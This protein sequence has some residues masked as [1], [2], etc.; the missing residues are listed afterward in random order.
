MHK[1]NVVVVAATR[2]TSLA[3][4]L[5]ALL[6]AIPQIDTVEIVTTLE[7]ALRRV[8]E[9]KPGLLLLDLALAGKKPKVILERIS[10]LSPAT[11]RVLLVE[12][13]RDLR[14]KP[15][16]AEAALVKGASPAAIVTILTD[17]LPSEDGEKEISP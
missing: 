10:V 11:L 6:K 5:E 1:Q 7:G 3:A 4:G 14:W 16:F 15:R 17:L 13:V 8:E 2:S 9:R 12:D